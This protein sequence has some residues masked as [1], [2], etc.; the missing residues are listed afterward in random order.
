MAKKK[1]LFKNVPHPLLA[2]GFASLALN[3]IFI[4]III[5]GNV[6]EASG[7]FDN[8]TVY[9]GI[10]RLCSEEY[11]QSVIESSKERGESAND[12]GMRLALVD[13][14][15]SNNGAK[16]FYEKGVEDYAKSLGLEP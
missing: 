1:S 12:S 9:S 7:E 3:A 8:A 10:E 13:F 5:V 6:L 16:E 11:R 14:P 4:G 15:C 2:V